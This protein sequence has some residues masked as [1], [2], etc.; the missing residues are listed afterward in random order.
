[1][2]EE[3]LSQPFVH[4]D[5][6]GNIRV[7]TVGD[8]GGVLLNNVRRWMDDGML[9]DALHIGG[10]HGD[11]NSNGFGILIRGTVYQVSPAQ[12]ANAVSR[13]VPGTSLIYDHL[14]TCCGGKVGAAG[15]EFASLRGRLLLSY[16]EVVNVHDYGRYISFK[17]GLDASGKPM[18]RPFSA[19]AQY[20]ILRDATGE[21]RGTIPFQGMRSWGDPVP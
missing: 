20:M 11:W 6:A 21:L 17:I 13:W 15:S 14:L 1:V 10:F 3:A 4:R 18:Y 7:I 5:A 8:E 16:D 19:N 9:R 2:V 12:L